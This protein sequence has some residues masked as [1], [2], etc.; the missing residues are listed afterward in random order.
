M[1]HILDTS[2][3][4]HTILRGTTY[5]LN[6]RVP[7]AQQQLYGRIIRV[8]LSNDRNIAAQLADHV[9][10]VLRK[11]WRSGA[12]SQL[13]VD[14]LVSSAKPKTY[15]MSDLAE[16]YVSVRQIDPSPVFVATRLLFEVVG[17]RDVRHY[18]REDARTFLHRLQVSGNK[19][20]TTVLRMLVSPHLSSRHSRSYRVLSIKIAGIHQ[21]NNTFLLVVLSVIF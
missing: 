9:V 20:S 7:K 14:V 3:P 2:N 18:T 4:T 19:T 12:S 16:E 5:Y 11:T 10:S 13:D 15:L 8:R 21:Q 1:A 6:L 17:D